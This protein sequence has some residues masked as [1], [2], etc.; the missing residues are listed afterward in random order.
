MWLLDTVDGADLAAAD[1]DLTEE[2]AS[3]L[4]LQPVDREYLLAVHLGE[5]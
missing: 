3:F 5:S 2:A 1:E 4:V